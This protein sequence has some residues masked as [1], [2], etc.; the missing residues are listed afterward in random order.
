M[1]KKN[2]LTFVSHNMERLAKT[3]INTAEEYNRIFF[4][5]K[6]RGVDPFDLKR[7][8][9]L[10]KHYKRGAILDIGCLDSQICRLV[11]HPTNY[12]G[13]DIAQQAIDEMQRKNQA[14]FFFVQDLYHLPEHWANH[15]R[16]IVMGEVIEHL[17]KPKEA[18]QEAF[19]VLQIGGIL[20]L[21]VPFN[22]HK[23]E[24][25]G[26]RHLWS[27]RRSD[28]E[29]LLKI[30]GKVWT[31]LFP[32]IHIPFTKYHHKNIIAFCRKAVPEHYR[33]IRI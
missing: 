18:L 20:A 5:R 22:E 17:E 19:R 27:F 10:L 1:K 14:S 23:G 32:K 13:I 33:S 26:E 29:S 7:W 15:F 16:Y 2:P 28:I 9:K 31:Q 24:V 25:D 30:H 3:N 11:K 12:V 4:E 21:S 6:E 8:K